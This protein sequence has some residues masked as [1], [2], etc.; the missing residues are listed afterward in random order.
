MQISITPE[1]E[2][3]VN[4][5]IQNGLYNSANELVNDALRLLVRKDKL[6]KEIQIGLDQIEAGEITSADK[7]KQQMADFKKQFLNSSNG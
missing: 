1:F 2:P 5:Q 6:Q 3:F 4:A 7:L